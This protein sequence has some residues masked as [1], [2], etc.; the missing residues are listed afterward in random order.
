[1]DPKVT[2]RETTYPHRASL[3]RGTSGG[4]LNR[5]SN[6]PIQ[7]HQLWPG[8]RRTETS[9]KPGQSRIQGLPSEHGD[10]PEDPIPIP[11]PIPIATSRSLLVACLR[12]SGRRVYAINPMEVARYRDRH[13]MSRKK[14]GHQDAVVLANVLRTD[15]ETDRLLGV[16]RRTRLRPPGLV[17]AA[18]GRQTRVLLAQLDTACQACDDLAQAAEELFLQRPDAEIITIFPGLTVLT[19][20]RIL[21]EIGDHRTRFNTARD[22]KPMPVLTGGTPGR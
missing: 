10:S 5:R 21:A 4:D 9:R 20:A 3:A 16:L 6:E 14:S 17:E 18:M 15:A 7:G 2:L 1:M 13:A 11:I 19:G 12:A 22:L 8:P